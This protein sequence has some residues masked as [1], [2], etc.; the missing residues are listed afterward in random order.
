MYTLD[1]AGGTEYVIGMHP[2]EFP[3]RAEWLC[4]C[5]SNQI[6]HPDSFAAINVGAY[7]ACHS[8]T[9]G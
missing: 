9:T 5:P 4:A 2:A 8:L 1:G 3:Q 7:T 6:A